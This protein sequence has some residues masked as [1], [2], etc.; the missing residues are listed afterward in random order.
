MSEA[1]APD[2]TDPALQPVELTAPD[3]APH[4]DGN[5]GI[6]YAH[7]RKARRPGPHVLV[8]AIVH[9]NEL[10]GAIALDWALRS[11]LAPRRGRLSMA[12]CNV[13]AYARFDPERPVGSRY[14]DED[15]NRVWDTETLDGPRRSVELDRARALRPLVDA[16]DLLLDIH[17]MQH[18]TEPL[19][20]A[21][22]RA[23]GRALARAVGTPATV[24]ADGGHAAGRR[25]RDYGAFDDEHDPRNALLAECGQH[26]AAD[27]ARVA[28][29]VLLRFLV[30][31]GT[32]EATDAAPWL[33]PEPPSPQRVIEV[34]DAWTIRT[35]AFRFLRPF[36][37]MEIIPEA[38]TIIGLDGE[39]PLTTPY[40]DCVLIMP[41]RRQA[42]GQTAVRMG[43][44]I[45]PPR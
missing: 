24:V 7:T 15:F 4:R 3:L 41:S 8:T 25:L 12:F 39:T 16:A 35:D 18:R 38:G 2:P 43:R 31:A 37:G 17:S 9:G 13:E 21:G 1:R 26:W 23:K 22:P 27:S 10:C 19:A 29:E 30:A 34:T 44:V 28:R 36:V 6:P 14:V 11:G 20:M 32:L 40:D 42:R 45:D 5:A 33:P